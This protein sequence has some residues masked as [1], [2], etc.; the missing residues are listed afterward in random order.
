MIQ[1]NSEQ[2]NLLFGQFAMIVN[3]TV[4]N[5]IVPRTDNILVYL[6]LNNVLDFKTNSESYALYI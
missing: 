1:Y 3:H 4:L 6:V 2:F 5:I